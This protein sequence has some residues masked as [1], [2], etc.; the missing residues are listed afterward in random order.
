RSN[1][2]VEKSYWKNEHS[3]K[4]NDPVTQKKQNELNA[5]MTHLRTF[6]LN[7]FEKTEI[8]QINKD[9][10]LNVIKDYYNPKEERQNPVEVIP[11]L[12]VDY[13]PYFLEYRK[14]EMSQTSIT[15]YNV[16]KHK[17]Q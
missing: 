10:F 8:D 9:W 2:E 13:I 5:K 4:S 16:I 14:H 11:S 12:L 17:L 7:A 3:K 15:K 1:I 6:V